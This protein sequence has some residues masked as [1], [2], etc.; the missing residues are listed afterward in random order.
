MLDNWVDIMTIF[1]LI[2]YALQGLQRGFVLGL[3]DLA[4]LVLS[5]LVALQFY[6]AGAA[7]LAPYVPLSD[8]LLKPIAFLV[9]WLLSDVVV[10]LLLRVLGLPLRLLGRV[11]S[12]NG[13]LGL[14]PG[15]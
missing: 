15:C 10:T 14:I 11:S 2:V 1:V 7:L 9:L 8:A 13:L 3:L 4:G 6:V 5:L 12:V